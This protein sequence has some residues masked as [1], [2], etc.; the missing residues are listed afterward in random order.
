MSQAKHLCGSNP[1]IP[2]TFLRP[3]PARLIAFCF[4]AFVSGRDTAS[5][6]LFST[7]Q[8]TTATHLGLNPILT[9]AANTDGGVTGKMI[10]PQ[11]IAVATA[12]S[13]LT[14]QEGQLFR[15][16]VPHSLGL[17]SISC[18]E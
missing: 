6:A 8:R 1:P 17:L 7:M 2:S 15:M 12:S 13:K 5:N 3:C 10:S 11:S 14:G 16:A 4:G 18:E 9:I